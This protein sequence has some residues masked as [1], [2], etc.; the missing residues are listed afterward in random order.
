MTKTCPHGKCI[1]HKTECN[2][3]KRAHKSYI[4]RNRFFDLFNPKCCG[5]KMQKIRCEL[6]T[7]ECSVCGG[8]VETEVWSNYWYKHYYCECCKNKMWRVRLHFPPIM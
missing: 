1:G 2:P 4:F 8:E 6:F 5:K 7:V 3:E